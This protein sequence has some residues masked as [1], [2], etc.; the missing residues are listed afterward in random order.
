MNYSG[1]LPTPIILF[2]LF[3]TVVLADG[4]LIDKIYHPYV[5]PQEK[6]FEIR[7]GL[8]S[9]DVDN[10][11]D[12]IDTY[13]FAYGQSLNDRWFAEFYLIGKKSPNN[14]FDIDTA[15]LELLWQITEQGEYAA[16]WGMLFELERS[17]DDDITEIST[18][19]LVERQWRQW[20][21][22]AN[23][24]FIYEWGDDIESEME[25]GLAL[26]TRY[27]Y[28]RSLEPA[29][30]LYIGENS[31]GIGPVLLGNVRLGGRKQ[32]RW[33]TGIIAGLN[34]DTPDTTFKFL[35]ELEFY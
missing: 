13:R 12:G 28:S 15:E 18:A 26:Q 19:F 8:Q 4:S 21:G 5:Q 11:G 23:F 10:L 35:I 34:D 31:K 9:D 7:G 27:R 17:L 14:S 1:L 29:I 33:E 22:T 2:F 24:H 32:L 30:E 16:D 25:T 6:E 3:P 20:V